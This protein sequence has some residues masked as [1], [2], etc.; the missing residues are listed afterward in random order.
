MLLLDE[1]G[2]MEKLQHHWE[3]GKAEAPQVSKEQVEGCV[4]EGLSWLHP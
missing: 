3:V 1:A 4:G 2:L